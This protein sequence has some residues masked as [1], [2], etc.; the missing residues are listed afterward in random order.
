[1]ING[2]GDDFM[3]PAR[4]VSAKAIADVCSPWH[5]VNKHLNVLKQKTAKA[6]ICTQLPTTALVD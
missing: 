2:F 6:D 1:M 4:W 5:E 3:I